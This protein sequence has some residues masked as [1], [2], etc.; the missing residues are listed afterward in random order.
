MGG[1]R[2]PAMDANPVP[3]S[4]THPDNALGRVYRLDDDAWRRRVS[5]WKKGR[6][7]V[8]A[9]YFGVFIAFLYR[10]GLPNPG[11][12]PWVIGGFVGGGLGLI[13]LLLV[14][15]PSEPDT[16]EL[17][18]SS[19][20][21]HRPNGQRIALSLEH[22][23]RVRLVDQSQFLGKQQRGRS[24]HSAYVILHSSTTE[25]ISVPHDAFQ[26]IQDRLVQRGA[27]LV[28]KRPLPLTRDSV[29]WDYRV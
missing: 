4:A 20:V 12:L 3:G 6:W 16:L 21:L 15:Y 28:S 10:V 9:L 23:V 18:P 13:G 19:I 25:E 17:G 7:I 5:R 8:V 24:T 11:L 29:V 22:G 2:S 27:T 26:A 14:V 1:P